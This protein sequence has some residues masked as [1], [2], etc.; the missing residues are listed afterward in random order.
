VDGGVAPCGPPP[1][2]AC[3]ATLT[4]VSGRRRGAELIAPPPPPPLASR[5]RDGG[6]GGHGGREPMG[7]AA[8]PSQRDSG[9]RAPLAGARGDGARCHARWVAARRPPASVARATVSQWAGRLGGR[10]TLT[11]SMAFKE[12]SEKPYRHTDR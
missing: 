6:G 9:R 2:D 10:G 3:R 1:V 5:M 4:V 7:R 11:V 12:C 8:G